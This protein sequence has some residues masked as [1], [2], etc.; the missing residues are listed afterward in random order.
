M[1]QVGIGGPT[2]PHRLESAVRLGEP[3]RHHRLTHSSSTLHLMH[4]L[5]P[6]L[7]ISLKLF[8][9]GC[10]Q[11]PHYISF[12]T[13][14]LWFNKQPADSLEVFIDQRRVLVIV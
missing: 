3:T 12:K 13:E 8:D 11:P 2:P 14:T 4:H 10:L 7:H 1:L 9:W 5:C 6:S